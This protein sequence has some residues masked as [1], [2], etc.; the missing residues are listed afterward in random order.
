MSNHPNNKSGNNILSGDL[1][2]ECLVRFFHQVGIFY[3]HYNYYYKQL[4][5]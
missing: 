4:I 1:N 2:A 3:L 5:L